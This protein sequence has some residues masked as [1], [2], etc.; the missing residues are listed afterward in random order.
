MKASFSIRTIIIDFLMHLIQQVNDEINQLQNED[1]LTPT[2][3]R[4]IQ[5]SMKEL[6]NKLDLTSTPLLYELTSQYCTNLGNT[7]Y[8]GNGS[9]VGTKISLS[10]VLRY[11]ET[12]YPNSTMPFLNKYLKIKS[13][14][15][16]RR[17]H[18]KIQAHIRPF[19]EKIV[20]AIKTRSRVLH[21]GEKRRHYNDQSGLDHQKDLVMC[22]YSSLIL[23]IFLTSSFQSS[24]G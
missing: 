17:N 1:Q 7:V 12:I 19:V 5:L 3:S 16:K 22:S 10:S 9:F 11:K 6:L 21:L 2:I 24:C 15:P 23:C 13:F 4:K 14:V 20:C 8:P 18:H